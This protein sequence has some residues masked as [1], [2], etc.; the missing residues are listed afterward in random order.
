MSKKIC[1][2]ENKTDK[3]TSFKQNF[4]VS[5]QHFPFSLEV[6]GRH[7]TS[8][9]HVSTHLHSQ[10]CHAILYLSEIK[11]W[12]EITSI[13]TDKSITELLCPFSMSDIL[14]SFVLNLENIV[15]LLAIFQ[16]FMLI[17]TRE[18]FEKWKIKSVVYWLSSIHLTTLAICS[19]ASKCH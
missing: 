13:N 4:S 2:K 10:S 19:S 17:S 7:L 18:K 1:L 11:K 6:V 8:L 9:E 12:L 16:R 3:F 15:W 14:S 5:L